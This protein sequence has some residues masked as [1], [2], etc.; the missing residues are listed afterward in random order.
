MDLRWQV[1]MM[2]HVQCVLCFWYAMKSGH[3]FAAVAVS[4][5]IFCLGLGIPQLTIGLFKHTA[6]IIAPCIHVLH[7]LQRGS[8][9]LG[10]MH[11]AD[12]KYIGV[13]L[14]FRW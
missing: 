3:H 1:V 6:T 14:N 12:D 7:T 8:T 10:I 2:T 9:E 5:I 11:K 13:K 4:V